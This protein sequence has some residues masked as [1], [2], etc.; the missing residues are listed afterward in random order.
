MKK[1]NEIDTSELKEIWAALDGTELPHDRIMAISKLIIKRTRRWPVMLWDFI[2]G[3]R[4]QEGYKQRGTRKMLWDF[5]MQA[6]LN[7]Q[8]GFPPRKALLPVGKIT[9]SRTVP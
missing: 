6:L 4:K 2:T 1:V 9:E 8:H 5:D 3:I 7:A